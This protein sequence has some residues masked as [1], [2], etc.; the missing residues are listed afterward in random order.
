[1]APFAQ[2]GSVEVLPASSCEAVIGRGS[3]ESKAA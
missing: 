2:V 1:M 3:C